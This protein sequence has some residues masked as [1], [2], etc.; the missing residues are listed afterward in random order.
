[1]TQAH[2][3]LIA[4]PALCLLILTG[5]LAMLHVSLVPVGAETSRAAPGTRPPAV[6]GQFYPG[7]PD[8]LRQ[9]VQTLLAN[10]QPKVH[11][12]AEP[13]VVA[14]IV[15]HAGYVYSGPTAAVGF[16]AIEKLPFDRTCFLGVDHRS[17]RPT[18]SVWPA[19]GFDCPMGVTPIDASL[20]QQ[21]IDAGRPITVDPSQHLAEHSLEVLVPF[22]QSTFGGRQA[23]FVTV[24]GPPEN[25]LHLGDVL[26]DLVASSSERFLFIVSTDWSH[27]H[28]AQTAAKLDQAGIDQVLALNEEQLLAK[29]RTG[30]TELCG[31]NGVLAVTRLMRRLG[32][33]AVLLEHTDSAK[34]SGDQTQV[35][36]Y[37]AI[38]L[39]ACPPARFGGQGS[40][41]GDAGSTPGSAPSTAVSSPALPVAAASA[42]AAIHH[43][44]SPMS[45]ENQ[46]FHE[47]AL[48]AVRTTL[49]GYLKDGTLPALELKSKRFQEVC[50]VFVTLKKH[51]ELRGCI[52][53]IQGVKPLGKGIQEMAVAA[54]T[55]DPRFPAVTLS[56]L[57]ELDIEISVLTPMTPVKD[58]NEIQVGRD[59]LLLRR[60]YHSGLLLPQV[61]TEYGW[62]RDTF[63]EHLCYKAGLPKGSHLGEDAQLLR[64][65]AEVFGEKER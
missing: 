44:E 46:A 26:Y 21:L 48:R 8:E 49:T 24:G 31:L 58:L 51:G 43:Q 20:S 57:A 54:A 18:I 5:C 19:G 41:G 56:E 36:G 17:G 62:D 35:V 10:V 40:A 39:T 23:A 25:G 47:E 52:G 30:E 12:P 61:A 7:N 64:F 29:C 65:S 6:A 45:T 42:S 32:G 22:F 38:L 34:A 37:A 16:R 60:G 63:L 11:C 1:M 9:T 33:S 27:Y 50:G 14:L 13:R 2:S 28:D 55:E 4:R 53:L 15:P 59:G 3:R